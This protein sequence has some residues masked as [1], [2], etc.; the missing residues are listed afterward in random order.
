MYAMLPHFWH[1]M[2]PDDN[3]TVAEQHDNQSSVACIKQINMEYIIPMKEMQHIHLCLECGWGH[4][5]QLDMEQPV[6]T[7]Q[8][9]VADEVHEAQTQVTDTSD[10]LKRFQLQPT[11]MKGQTLLDHIMFAHCQI[12]FK[13]QEKELYAPKDYLNLAMKP[14]NVTILKH[15]T[16]PDHLS[17]RSAMQDCAGNGAT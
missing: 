8:P 4:P 2:P 1:A 5:S 9:V 10:G 12:S 17:K 6:L 13:T 11:G 3:K 14:C 16:A 15:M 7:T